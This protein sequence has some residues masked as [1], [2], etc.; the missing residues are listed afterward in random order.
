[1]T[2]T[3]ATS[4][5]LDLMFAALADATR[6]DLIARLS[7][8][9]DATVSDLA[10]PYAVSLQAI[11]KHLRVLE[12]AGLVTRSREAQR[13]PVSLRPEALGDLTHWL[14]EHRRRAEAR[15]RRLDAVLES[16]TAQPDPPDPHLSPTDPPSPDK[17]TRP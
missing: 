3:T 11:S 1:M 9:P 10:A 16:L 4:R 5:E 13:R 6:R 14:E 2:S 7:R 8:Q 17:D 15:Y 12:H